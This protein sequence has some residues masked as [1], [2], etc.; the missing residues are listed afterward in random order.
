MEQFLI[1][2][3]ENRFKTFWGRNIKPLGPTFSL[4]KVGYKVWITLVSQK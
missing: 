1:L 2:I 3:Q 4:W